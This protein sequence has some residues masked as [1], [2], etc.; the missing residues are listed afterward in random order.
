MRKLFLY[1]AL[2]G[3]KSLLS[4]EI[5]NL[6]CETLSQNPKVHPGQIIAGDVDNITGQELRERAGISFSDPLVIVG[7]PPCQPFSKASYWT[8]PGDDS[9]YRQARMQGIEMINVVHP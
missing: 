4:M 9:K 7:G 1:S 3:G 8:D 5:D 2:A 6:C